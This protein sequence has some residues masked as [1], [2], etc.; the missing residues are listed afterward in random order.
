MTKWE[1]KDLMEESAKY[2]EPEDPEQFYDLKYESNGVY[3]WSCQANCENYLEKVKSDLG[4]RDFFRLRELF[5]C[6]AGVI[7]PLQMGKIESYQFHLFMKDHDLYT[8]KLDRTQSNLKFFA[9]NKTKSITFE[10]FCR[11]ICELALEKYPWEKNRSV[12]FRQFVKHSVFSKRFYEKEKKFEKVLD[13][14]YTPQVQDFLTNKKKMEYFNRFFDNN[15]K[16]DTFDSEVKDTIDLVQGTKI[17]I[18]LS[19]IPDLIS[20]VNFVKLFKF[21]QQGEILKPYKAQHRDYLTRE[22]FRN[23]I[24]SI[25]IFSYSEDESLKEKFPLSVQRAVSVMKLYTKE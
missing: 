4:D 18:E 20:K 12:V 2:K 5:E 14:L 13:E 24:A 25:G 10:G 15:C 11:I 3:G 22:E 6:Y 21:C 8:P 16:R 19:I 23:L 17:S 7:S 1:R 9:C